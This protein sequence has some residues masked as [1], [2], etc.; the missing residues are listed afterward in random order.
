MPAGA[1]V[2]QFSLQTGHLGLLA[3][4]TPPDASDGSLHP[5][6]LVSDLPSE[7]Q[8]GSRDPA[9]VTDLFAADIQANVALLAGDGLNLRL[10]PTRNWMRGAP[11]AMADAIHPNPLGH[12]QLATAFDSILST[13]A[14]AAITT[15][16]PTPV[17]GSM[18]LTTPGTRQ[19]TAI[20]S[21]DAVYAPAMSPPYPVTVQDGSTSV[22]L[23]T[24][25][26]SVPY[27]AS[28]PITATVSPA[29]AIG[30]V[31]FLAN[32]SIFTTSQTVAGTASAA[33]TFGTGPVTLTATFNAYDGRTSSVSPPI[34]VNV[35]RQGATLSLV[36]QQQGPLQAQNQAQNLN[37]PT[38]PSAVLTAY[39]APLSATGNVTFT[40]PQTGLNL[41]APIVNGVAI[42]SVPN[43]TPGPHNYTATYSGDA[44]YAP[45]TSAPVSLLPG[46][47]TP[48]LIAT[49]LTDPASP[50]GTP[51]SI[52]VD[53]LAQAVP[54]VPVVHA[55]F[56]KQLNLST[57]FMGDSITQWWPMPL[58]DR[59]IAGQTTDQ[60]L[61]RFESDVLNQ[62]F[63]R[64]VIL[65]GT[66]D[67]IRG[68]DPALTLADLATMTV[69]AQSGGLRPILATIPPIFSNQNA[70][71]AQVFSLNAGIRALARQN[72]LL[73]VD[74][75]AVLVQHPEFFVDGIHPN[76]AGYTAMETALAQTLYVPTG[77][78]ALSDG[79]TATLSAIGTATLISA[80]VPGGPQS[81]TV[82][83]AGDPNLAPVSA[84][85]QTDFAQAASATMLKVQPLDGF[86]G[87]A[88]A[89]SA[90]VVGP[91]SL[92]ASGTITFFDNGRPTGS[93]AL[94][95][96]Q[97]A[98]YTASNLA[99]GAHAFTASYTG[100]NSFTAS[101]SPAITLTSP[102]SNTSLA[103]STA[104]PTAIA[105]TPVTLTANIT[106]TAAT[107]SITFLDGNAVLAQ[108][109][110]TAGQATFTT[111]SLALGPH[112]LTATY[113]GD[114]NDS[115]AASP[116]LS[117]AIKPSPTTLTLASLPPTQVVGTPVS[118][119][120]SITPA[121]ATGQVTYLDS[122]TAPNQPQ[123][124]IQTL[125]QANL[126]AGLATLSLPTM[127]VGSH[128][129]SATYAGDPKNVASTS[130]P[131]TITVSPLTAAIVLTTPQASLVYLTPA[132]FTVSVSPA[133]ATGSVTLRDGSGAQ[134]GKAPLANA[135]ATFTL[136]NLPLG[137]HSFS[138]AYSGDLN[139]SAASSLPVAITITPAATTLTLAPLPTPISAGTSV[140]LAVTIA[141]VTA[142]GTVTFRDALTGTLGQATLAA[143]SATLTLPSL[144]SGAYTISAAY[145]G[146]AQDAP[147]VSNLVP[148]KVTLTPT[149]T[150]LAS[151]P[152]QLA[153][154]A[155]LTLTATSL[156]QHQHRQHH[157]LRWHQLTRHLPALKRSR[158]PA[159]CRPPHRHPYPPRRVRWRHAAGCLELRHRHPRR[160]RKPHQ[161]HPHRRP[162][163]HHGR[164]PDHLQHPRRRLNRG[165]PHRLHRHPFCRRHH[166][167][168]H[169][170][171]RPGQRRLRDPHSALH[172]ARA[173]HLPRH[174]RLRGGFRQRRFGQ[175]RHA[176]QPHHRPRRHRP[177]PGHD[178]HR[179]AG[180]DARPCLDHPHRPLTLADPHR[181]HHLRPQRRT[182]PH[183]P[184]R[185]HRQSHH[186]PPR[187]ARRQLQP[188][189]YLH[190]HRHLR[191]S[192]RAPPNPHL[193]R[194]RVAHL[195]R[196]HPH[197]DP[198][199][200]HRHQ[201]AHH[202]TFRLYR[203]H[204]RPVFHLRT[205]P[206]LHARR[207]CLSRQPHHSRRPPGARECR[208]RHR[209]PQPGP[210]RLRPSPAAPPRRSPRQTPPGPASART[211]N[212]RRRPHRLCLRK[213]LQEHPQRLPAR[214]RHRHRQPDHNPGP[215]QYPDQGLTSQAATTR[216]E[217]Q[218]QAFP[219]RNRLPPCPSA[220]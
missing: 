100:D 200:T 130:A 189:R 214:H 56:P 101:V 195:C 48:S 64:V 171:P 193:H 122:Y 210:H 150:T 29:D 92:G 11:E 50:A 66:N 78:I 53:L 184:R 99:P 141:P 220:N 123:A 33:E 215:A 161:H 191:P 183:H 31:T 115:I 68:V 196:R 218:P 70:L 102:F 177:H 157:V 155:P 108:Q 143:G 65:G 203:R 59:G 181:H 37:Q 98:T 112:A 129:I 25:S 159:A 20:Y 43:L 28:I 124:T 8:A 111:A 82:S 165:H 46:T 30:T 201:P 186:H 139:D 86:A 77:S 38:L 72:G 209:S 180:P 109:P 4:G 178:R 217:E 3:V 106:P 94:A 110:L 83:Y 138:A 74:Y 2:I 15:F 146:D 168:R 188:C 10:V 76:P 202:A 118:L 24:P 137:L 145:A 160:R 7:N 95:N 35:G 103:L 207:P 119:T 41:T 149:V 208:H 219:V 21:G 96:Q 88:V 45:F 27:L 104:A 39:L 199:L 85:I 107:G 148:L 60:M 62:G 198:R 34:I 163:H 152:A 147:T 204:R 132:T 54:L 205:L 16:L 93:A 89:F 71:S 32:G 36:A 114:A 14:P 23:T 172:P 49:L 142:T 113:A 133:T 140:T 127:P 6:V 47:I 175:L 182:H 158:H 67:T 69:Q 9:S 40:E 13:I 116:V 173:R 167:L 18:L 5:T 192:H 156:P 211:R 164:R 44:V 80:P 87:N 212:G 135:T 131:V 117:V 55:T 19:L 169:T 17:T 176:H 75:Y 91:A 136:A 51:A 1:H 125:G 190:A 12:A 22:T 42:L 174:R 90:A 128:V 166:R 153:L 120:A 213:H 105:G 144:P 216:I 57:V 121:A 185:R 134:V 194:T 197:H 97:P 154:G 79:S 26:L 81:F 170:H 58:N 84:I 151:L 162:A 126:N 52:H 63:S 179:R 206:H 61:G 187:P 73:V